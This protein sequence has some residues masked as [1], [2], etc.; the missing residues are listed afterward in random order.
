MNVINLPEPGAVENLGPLK[1]LRPP[2]F[3][4]AG[5]GVNE[6]DPIPRP[7]IVKKIVNIQILFGA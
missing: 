4:P 3:R 7:T 2:P 1:R 5:G 6:P